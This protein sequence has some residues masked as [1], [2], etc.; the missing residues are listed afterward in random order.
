MKAFKA[1]IRAC[2]FAGFGFLSIAAA[3]AED[4][5]VTHYGSTALRRAVCDRYGEGLLQG[6][7]RRR[8]RYPDVEGRR[9]QRPAT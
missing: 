8:D 5:V 4:I 6:S 9:Y 7:R 3:R 2:A 1:A